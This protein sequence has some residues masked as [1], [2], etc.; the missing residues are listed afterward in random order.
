MDKK[1]KVIIYTPYGL[2]LQTEADY[3][4]TT[5]AVGVIGILPNHAPLVSTLEI[6]KLV[7]KNNSVENIYAIGG[8]VIHIKKDHTVVLLVNSIESK[9][10]IDIE[11]AY[12]AKKR[13]E[14]RLNGSGDGLE[15]NRA[16]LSLLRAINRIEV[17]AR[18]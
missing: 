9:D 12:A 7:I 2:Y 6:S 15:I 17:G 14:D 16:K 13:A 18:K 11:R 1:L 3:L 8:G 10:D 4:S 5:S